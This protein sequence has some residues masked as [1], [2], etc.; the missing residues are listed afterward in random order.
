MANID[1][2]N[3]PNKTALDGTEQLLLNDAGTPRDTT[4]A[5]LADYLVT[6]KKHARFSSDGKSLVGGG[7]K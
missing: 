7:W 6:I 1:L 4:P 2:S 3:L 5:V